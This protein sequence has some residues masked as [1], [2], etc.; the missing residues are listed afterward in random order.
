MCWEESTQEDGGEGENGGREASK[1]GAVLGHPTAQA[2]SPM[3]EGTKRSKER[4][5]GL[6]SPALDKRAIIFFSFCLKKNSLQP[7]DYLI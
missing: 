5:V 2:A 1:G 7:S 4:C 3:L 6:G